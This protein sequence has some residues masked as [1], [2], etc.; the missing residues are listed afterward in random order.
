MYV[1]WDGEISY[2]KMDIGDWWGDSFIKVLAVFKKV[3]T[4]VN[5]RNSS[6]GGGG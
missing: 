2:L 1:V 5:V 4:T 6:A 3:D